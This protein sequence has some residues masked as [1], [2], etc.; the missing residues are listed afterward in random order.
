MTRDAD[1]NRALRAYGE[2]CRDLVKITRPLSWVDFLP[3]MSF[4]LGIACALAYVF[5]TT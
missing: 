1:E 3:L 5:L 4:V 2:L